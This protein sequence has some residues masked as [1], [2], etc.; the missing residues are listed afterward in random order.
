MPNYTRRTPNAND[1]TLICLIQSAPTGVQWK[2]DSWVTT[3]IDPSTGERA[4]RYIYARNIGYAEALQRAIDWRDGKPVPEGHQNRTPKLA[5]L[6]KLALTRRVMQGKSTPIY[7]LS[8]QPSKADG[9]HGWMII[10]LGTSATVTQQKIDDAIAT[11][12]ARLERYVGLSCHERAC[13]A[14]EISN[15]AI[16]GAPAQTRLLMDDVLAWSGK[17]TNVTFYPKAPA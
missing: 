13:A 11:L 14:H 5:R 17:G 7:E 9:K 16:A 15:I 12:V 1:Q 10:A 8:V 3:R 6:R 2:R 4:T